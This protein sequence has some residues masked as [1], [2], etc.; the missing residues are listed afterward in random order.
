M[1]P[2][3]ASHNNSLSCGSMLR[4]QIENTI[5]RFSVG[6]SIF[7]SGKTDL[8]LCSWSMFVQLIDYIYD[9]LLFLLQQER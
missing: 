9:I 7:T 6:D 1:R 3:G 8:Y 2:N 4:K 5:D